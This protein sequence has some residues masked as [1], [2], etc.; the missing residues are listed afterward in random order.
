[1]DSGNKMAL[2]SRERSKTYEPEIF[3]AL[4]KIIMSP[5]LHCLHIQSMQF[6]KYF[7]HHTF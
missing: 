7:Y 1:M 6:T 5:D 3:L 2:F 4:L